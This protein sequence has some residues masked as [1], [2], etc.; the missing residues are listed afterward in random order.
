MA[1]PS[2]DEIPIYQE[3]LYEGSQDP[4]T[5]FRRYEAVPDGGASLRSIPGTPGGMYRTGGL[6]HDVT[7]Q[8]G[9][10]PDLRNSNVAR[11]RERMVAIDASLSNDANQEQ[12]V[13]GNHPC[14]VISWGSSAGAA[15]EAVESLHA[16]GLDIGY[17]FPRVLWPMPS[18]AIGK[19]IKS[20]IRT[21]YICEVND[22]QQFAQLLRA[23]FATE[24]QGTGVEV[25]GVN[26]DSGSP[27]S[28]R[29]IQQR[30]QQLLNKQV[31]RIRQA[32]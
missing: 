32:V 24:L 14:A 9:F 25:V 12:P 3:P 30:L 17:L 5:K 20:G 8:P 27:F 13:L 29:D 28:A 15:R 6:E 23:N 19:F 1:L 26:Q 2:L 18:A 16:Q 7:G 10:D 21:L 11:R 4:A 31:T 22:S